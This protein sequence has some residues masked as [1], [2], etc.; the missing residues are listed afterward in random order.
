MGRDGDKVGEGDQGSFG[1]WIGR[2]DC[3]EWINWFGGNGVK[4]GCDPDS[5]L[6]GVSR[7]VRIKELGRGLSLQLEFFHLFFYFLFFSKSV[8]VHDFRSLTQN[9]PYPR[10]AF[11]PVPL[12]ANNS[13]AVSWLCWTHV[14]TR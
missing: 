9:S 11:D 8:P 6:R 7:K 14:C 10:R 2:R 13:S 3:K 12:H 4:L 1:E 5:G